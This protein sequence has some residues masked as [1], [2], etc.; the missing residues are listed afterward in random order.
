MSKEC[1]HDKVKFLG[2]QKGE[3]D[4]CPCM[5]PNAPQY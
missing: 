1:P 2:E 3:K 4:A 5:S